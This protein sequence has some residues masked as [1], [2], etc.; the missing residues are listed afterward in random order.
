VAFLITRSRKSLAEINVVPY[1]DVMLVLLV[2]F[3]VTAPLIT[4]GIS[5][6]LPKAEAPSLP[7]DE[8]P[9]VVSVDARGQYFISTASDPSQPVNLMQIRESIS[10]LILQ[11]PNTVVLIEGDEGVAYGRVIELM[12]LLK[13]IGQLKVGFVTQP[14]NTARKVN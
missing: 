14:D 13:S 8:A 1:I 7:Q 3:M 5:V 12:A 9:L 10:Q 6:E 11:K 4:Q 2:V